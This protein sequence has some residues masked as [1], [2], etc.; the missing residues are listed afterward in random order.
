MS[1]VRIIT[2]STMDISDGCY[3]ALTVLPIRIRFGEQEYLDGVDITKAGF[4]E[5][6][7]ECDTL[8]TTSQVTPFAFAEAYEKAHKAGEQV[9][10]LTVSAKLSGTYQSAVLA[11]QE[12]EAEVYVV[13]GHNVAIGSGIMVLYALKL[14]E[15]GKSAAQI[16]KELEQVRDRVKVIGLL[17]TLEY[18]KRGGRISKAVAFAG[19]LLSI[20]PVVTVRD[21]AVELLGKARGSK[22]GN[23][24]LVQQ[25]EA[26]GGVDFSMPILLGYSGLSDTLLQ[27]YIQDSSSLWEGNVEKLPCTSISGAVGTHVGPGA[28]AVAF[29][30]K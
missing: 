12:T 20:K 13:D 2:D 10:V 28:I 1:K 29:F 6:L 27:K 14:V 25:I 4:Y 15:Q 11:A 30:S 21:G 19:S 7:V 3:S 18:L 17:D 9:V 8:P 26:A 24:M 16:A 5:K 22:Q 23:N